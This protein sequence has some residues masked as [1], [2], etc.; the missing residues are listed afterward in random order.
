M[1]DQFLAE[2]HSWT[3]IRNAQ[4]NDEDSWV[5]LTRDGEIVPIPGEKILH[6]SRPRVSLELSTPRELQVAEPYSFK[7]DNGI[8]Y[9]TNQRVIFLPARRSEDF[10][11]FFSPVLNFT[12]THVRSSWIGPWSWGGVVKPV[13]GGG[14][15]MHIP[16]IEARLIFRDGGHSDFQTKFE[17]L[18][19]R[20]HHAQELGFSGQNLEPPPPYD[21]DNSGPSE[22]PPGNGP[23]SAQAQA[24]QQQQPPQPT[25]DE[26]PPD[27]VE[28]QSQA[29]TMQYEERTREEAERH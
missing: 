1:A 4:S 25:P 5:M 29:I 22:G 12:D 23:T 16:R 19:E 10:K 26:P 15:P 13:P 18:K 28:A 17:W 7:C 6:T 9:I 20:L 14:I 21:V 3:L 8:A 27:Y 2:Q 24:R 11:S